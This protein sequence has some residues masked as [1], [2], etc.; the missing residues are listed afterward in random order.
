VLYLYPIGKRVIDFL[1]VI[2]EYLTSC[3]SWGTTSRNISQFSA[4]SRGCVTLTL[5]LRLKG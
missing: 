1:Q 5:H 4:L 3:Y 2:N